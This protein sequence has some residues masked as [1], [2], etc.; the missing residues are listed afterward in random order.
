LILE[1]FLIL[2]DSGST[3][4]TPNGAI[5][6][7][8][9]ADV[10]LALEGRMGVCAA[11]I[12]VRGQTA[13]PRHVTVLSS[14]GACK[15]V[16]SSWADVVSEDLVQG[17]ETNLEEF[18]GI[19][20]TTIMIDGRDKSVEQPFVQVESALAMMDYSNTSYIWL[21]TV[22]GDRITFR[23]DV[24]VLDSWPEWAAPPKKKNLEKCRIE[25]IA[26]AAG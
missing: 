13:L 26:K 10:R 25:V 11:A 20:S 2:A 15:N 24:R 6:D 3:I 17:I 1:Q 16:G 19:L 21:G 23:P 12:Q 7:E 18:P 22:S 5:T 8:N 4:Q 9:V 14:A